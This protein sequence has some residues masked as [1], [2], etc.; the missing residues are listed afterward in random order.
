MDVVI[1]TEDRSSSVDVIAH[2]GCFT[3]Q[4]FDCPQ[5][6][7]CTSIIAD[8]EVRI[9]SANGLCR[10]IRR[11]AEQRTVLLSR[12]AIPETKVRARGKNAECYSSG[13]RADALRVGH[14][15]CYVPFRHCSSAIGRL[16]TNHSFE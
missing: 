4:V 5:R 6:H 3:R 2:L 8:G 16:E 7:A 14:V 1:F 13:K 10:E 11:E 12:P 15:L 9:E